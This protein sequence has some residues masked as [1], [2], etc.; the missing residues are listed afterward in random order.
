LDAISVRQSGLC[1]HSLRCGHVAV[2]EAELGESA[3]QVEDTS[4]IAADREAIEAVGAS[5]LAGCLAI[6]INI[7]L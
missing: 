4:V 6:S 7:D 2:E 3:A 1:L 5:T